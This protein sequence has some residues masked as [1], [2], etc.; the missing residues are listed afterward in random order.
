M[1]LI[2]R[3]IKEYEKTIKKRKSNLAWVIEI[4]L[5][6]CL[7]SFIFSILAEITIPKVN[8]ILGIVIV[9]FVIIIGVLFDMVGVAITT[10]S[11]V[12]FHSMNS[13]KIPGAKKA[14][15]LINNAEKVSSVCND[16]VGDICGIISGSVG[17]LIS[18]IIANKFGIDL[19]FISLIVTSLI[20]GLTIGGKALGKSIAIN[21]NVYIVYLISKILK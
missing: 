17:V 13:R 7:I 5:F 9:L 12:P 11:V 2:K 8:V 3:E 20:A 21:K 16:V 1:K 19:I 18:N 6:A 4:T 10:V 15:T 14:I